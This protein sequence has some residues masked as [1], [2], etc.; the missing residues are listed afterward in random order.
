MGKY[1]RYYNNHTN[2]QRNKNKLYHHRQKV[3]TIS[4]YGGRCTVCGE[5]NLS[6]LCIDHINNEGRRVNREHKRIYRW[7][8][9]NDF[10]TGFQV[11]CWNHN[12][13]KHLDFVKSGHTHTI[14][15]VYNRS[16]R[17][18]TKLIVTS[19]YGKICSCCGKDNIDV[20]TIDHVNGGGS[21]DR[22]ELG[23]GDAF[24]RWLINNNF[25]LGFQVLCFNCNSGRHINGGVCPHKKVISIYTN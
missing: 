9:K 1:G 18:R 14:P 16:R 8:I 13:L 2:K 10:P 6:F 7:L 4:H 21:Y 11:L 3:M 17:V 15:A 12:W 25:P 19:H 20:L 24:Y 5:T 22:K 23:S